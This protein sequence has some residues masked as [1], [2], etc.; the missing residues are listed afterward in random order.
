MRHTTSDETR[1]K[2]SRGLKRYYKKRRGQTDPDEPWDG[3]CS[4][5][6]WTAVEDRCRCKC[7]GRYHGAAKQRRLEELI[8]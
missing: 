7:R 3:I 8:Q 6:C 1:R 2:I 4:K 5:A